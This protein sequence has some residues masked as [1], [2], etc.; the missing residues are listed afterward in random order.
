MIWYDAP[1]GGIGFKI[2]ESAHPEYRIKI[3]MNSPDEVYYE[4]PFIYKGSELDEVTL[5][6]LGSYFGEDI[7]LTNG[8]KL[9]PTQ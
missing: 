3:T 5:T 8:E 7:D 9:V 4:G 2:L 6:D 1:D